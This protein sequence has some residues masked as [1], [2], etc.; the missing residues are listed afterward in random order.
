LGLKVYRGPGL[1]KLFKAKRPMTLPT[2]GVWHIDRKKAILKAHPEVADL[3]GNDPT[4]AF[5]ILVFFFATTWLSIKSSELVG[6]QQ[7]L[8]GYT[9][10]AY[11]SFCTITLGH[12]GVH[13][14]IFKNSFLNKICAIVAFAPAFLG[15][16]AMFWQSEH[17]WHHSIVVDKMERFGAANNGPIKKF[18]ICFLLYLVL[19]VGFATASAAMMVLMSV[20]MILY[21]LGIRDSLLPKSSRIPPFN[22]FPQCI[23]LWFFANGIFSYL[24]LSTLYFCYGSGPIIF[25]VMIMMFANG[26]H[27][28][29]MRNVQEHYGIQKSQPT[30]SVYSGWINRMTFSIGYH[31]EHHDFATIP[32]SRLHRLHQIA[33]EFYLTLQHYKSYSEVF[34]RFFTDPGIPLDVIFADNPLFTLG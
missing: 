3:C 27:P 12:D 24:Y 7:V 23:N 13:G 33:P 16:F 21:A 29:G 25:Q 8:I 19:N 9:L 22:R 15:P 6:W 28:L 17:L 32:L 18:L 5:W 4:T 31:V 34:Y 10:G 11:L 30:A 1:G 26:F 2:Q 14:L 20:H